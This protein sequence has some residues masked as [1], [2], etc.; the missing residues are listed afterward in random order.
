MLRTPQRTGLHLHGPA[1]QFLIFDSMLASLSLT[2]TRKRAPVPPRWPSALSGPTSWSPEP[3]S[4]NTGSITCR[5]NS[6]AHFLPLAP[7]E[8]LV[9]IEGHDPVGSVVEA[10]LVHV[11]GRDS[12]LEYSQKA[13]NNAILLIELHNL[14][15]E[16]LLR[17][18]LH[19]Q[20]L[21]DQP[22]KHFSILSEDDIVLDLNGF[23][24]HADPK[25]RD[26]EEVFFEDRVLDCPGKVL[27]VLLSWQVEIFLYFVEDKHSDIKERLFKWLWLVSLTT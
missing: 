12:S 24:P 26:L 4:L 3:P 10:A 16:V 19:N 23:N 22:H 14:P 7:G 6:E 21:Q 5:L 25:R 20:Q 13:D 8:G 1:Q 11:F 15:F 2:T 9:F 18:Q 27:R 17:H